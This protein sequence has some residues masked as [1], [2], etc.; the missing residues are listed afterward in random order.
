MSGRGRW[1]TTVDCCCCLRRRRQ[2]GW[3]CCFKTLK[4]L[5]V[6]ILV[7]VVVVVASVRRRMWKSA[8]PFD[9]SDRRPTAPVI[10]DEKGSPAV[11][12]P[13]QRQLLIVNKVQQQQV[14][15]LQAKQKLCKQSTC[16]NSKD[17]QQQ[18]M[19]KNWLEACWWVRLAVRIMW[20]APVA[21]CSMQCRFPFRCGGSSSCIITLL[22]LRYAVVAPI[23]CVANPL[24]QKRINRCNCCCTQCC[25]A[26][27]WLFVVA[28][29]IA[30]W[31]W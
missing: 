23:V 8:I 19:E 31:N 29:S 25:N 30:S 6:E 1:E 20:R 18:T 28:R 15:A 4:S 17:G 7:V 16:G 24:P 3:E 2:D 11:S 27:L 5:Q 14:A 9:N 21:R 10:A 13:Y 12:Q 22:C 26:L